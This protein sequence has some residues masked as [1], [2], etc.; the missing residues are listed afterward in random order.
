MTPG[1]PDAPGQRPVPRFRPRAAYGAPAVR[2]SR[3][4]RRHRRC[5]PW[6]AGSSVTPHGGNDPG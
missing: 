5:P 1:G 6:E 2:P 4:D 3:N